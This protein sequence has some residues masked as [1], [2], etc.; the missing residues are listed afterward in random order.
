MSDETD[1]GRVQGVLGDGILEALADELGLILGTLVS[2]GGGMKAF[3]VLSIQEMFLAVERACPD[4]PCPARRSL[5]AFG[6]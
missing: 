2:M 1:D 6:Q 3:E 5:R 4:H